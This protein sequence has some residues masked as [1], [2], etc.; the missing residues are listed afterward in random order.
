MTNL[1]YKVIVITGATGV[2]G[3]ALIER[4]T[5]LNPKKIIC[6]TRFERNLNHK[7]SSVIEWRKVNLKDQKKTVE[8]LN[9]GDLVFH[10]A[11]IKHDAQKYEEEFSYEDN[12]IITN[13]VVGACIELNIGKLIFVS[14]ALIYGI[15]QSLPVLETHRLDPISEYAKSKLDCEKI[16]SDASLSGKLNSIIVRACNIYGGRLEIDT[17]IGKIIS[18]AIEKSRLTLYNLKTER[19]FLH[20]V[21]V[22]NALLILSQWESSHSFIFNMSTGNAHS[23]QELVEIAQVYWHRNFN[24]SLPVQEKYPDMETTIPTIFLSNELI[25]KNTGWT[26]GIT[27]ERGLTQTIEKYLNK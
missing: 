1:L 21:D 16:I 8:A 3:E 17:V 25:C 5:E 4:L 20:I 26:P 2:I 11:G 18:Q 15:P 14:S 6:L 12:V 23:I 9:G 10:L 19:D 27:I 22:V 7:K 24:I 13:N